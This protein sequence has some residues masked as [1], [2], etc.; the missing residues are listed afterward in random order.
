MEINNTKRCLAAQIILE[1]YKSKDIPQ[2]ELLLW[3]IQSSLRELGYTEPKAEYSDTSESDA[4]FAA[5]P[6]QETSLSQFKLGQK[7]DYKGEVAVITRIDE[8]NKDIY[9]QVGW[10]EFKIKNLRFQPELLGGEEIRSG[11]SIKIQY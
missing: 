6:Y 7:F 5:Q 9:F 1:L 4:Y 8:E 10:T 3:Q 2:L 11:D